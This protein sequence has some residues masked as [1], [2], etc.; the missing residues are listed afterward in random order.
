MRITLFLTMSIFCCCIH[1]STQGQYEKEK[2]QP[3]YKSR[4]DLSL[5]L[6]ET[7]AV[8][9]QKIEFNYHL[10]V[11]NRVLIG[12]SMSYTNNDP[13]FI[14]ESHFVDFRFGVGPSWDL[15]DKKRWHVS[16]LSHLLYHNWYLRD[17]YTRF[18]GVGA[19]Q[20]LRCNVK[21]NNFGVGLSGGTS[22]SF[23]KGRDIILT[24]GIWMFD[25]RYFYAFNVALFLK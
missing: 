9:Y 3:S 16:T 18:Y 21:F 24:D 23:G 25:F 7:K 10:R 6:L 4:I 1:S 14:L 15:I 22:I 11:K 8:S 2:F 5:L 19:T 20:G 17:Y 13:K 12:A